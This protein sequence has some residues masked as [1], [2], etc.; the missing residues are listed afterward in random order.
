MTGVRSGPEHKPTINAAVT[1]TK[2]WHWKVHYRAHY[3][4]TNF[5]TSYLFGPGGAEK[6]QR[7]INQINKHTIHSIQHNWLSGWPSVATSTPSVKSPCNY[8]EQPMSKRTDWPKT[9]QSKE[10]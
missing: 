2:Q 4:V 3:A 10:Y 5:E 1:K 6:P 7:L 8:C 9:L